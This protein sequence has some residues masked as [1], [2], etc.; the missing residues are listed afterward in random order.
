MPK[1]M[2]PFAGKPLLE[3]QIELAREHGFANIIILAHYRA[4]LIESHFGDGR[5]FGVEISY[6]VEQQ[7]LG[8]AG[9]VLASFDKLAENFLVLCGDTMVNVD[10]G[11]IWERHLSGHADATLLVHP[12][13]HPFDSD[14]VEVDERGRVTAFHN[15]PHA[16]DCWYQ[17][18][19]SAGLYVIRKEA[20]AP[21]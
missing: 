15:R 19:V 1:P 17:N 3:Y 18:L 6:A 12:N 21:W 20:L 4:E 16:R 11:R 8:T 5:R 13:D 7:P 9:A 14:L 10:L 2:I